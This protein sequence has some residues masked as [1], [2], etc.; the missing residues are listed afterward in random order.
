MN[1]FEAWAITICILAVMLAIPSAI[2]RW[3]L[4]C[5]IVL[6]LGFALLLAIV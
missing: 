6:P 5:L 1:K 2:Y 3:L 4:M